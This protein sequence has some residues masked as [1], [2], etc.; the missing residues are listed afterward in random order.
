MVMFGR[1]CTLCLLVASFS[2]CNI[3]AIAQEVVHALTGTVTSMN[4]GKSIKV[5][6]DEGPEVDFQDMTKANIPLEFDK[7]LR[8]QATSADRFNT[9]GTH[10]IVYYFGEGDLRTAVALQG[11][12][13]GQ[14][15]NTIG[16][17]VKF[18]KHEHMMTVESAAGAV[19]SFQIGP[20]TVVESSVGAVDGRRFSPQKHDQLRVTAAQ[21]SD[22]ALFIFA[23]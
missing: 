7:D 19:Q 5:D 22:T 3:A 12:P 9:K 20:A 14:L 18:D 16:T 21:G 4:P 23:K 1:L 2:L 6:T 11:L 15:K 17:V 10:V 8:A 13:P